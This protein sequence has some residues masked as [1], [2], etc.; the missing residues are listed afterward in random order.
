MVARLGWA[1][2]VAGAPSYVG[3]ALRQ[4]MSPLVAGATATRPLGAISGVRPGTPSSTVAATSTTWTVTAFAGV[5]DLEAAAIAGPYPFS[6]DA[7]VT[8]AVTAANASYARIDILYVRVSDPAEGDGSS[9]PLIEVLYLAGTAAAVPAAPAVPARSFVIA[10][11]NVPVSGGG[12]P[13][14]TWNAP[15][16]VAAGAP[17]PVRSQA[18]RDAKF[19]T[20]YDGLAVY[21]LDT[22]MAETYNG[23]AW[24]GWIT[25]TATTTGFTVGTTGSPVAETMWRYEGNLVRLRYR[26]K[27]GTNGAT[28][29]SGGASFTLPVSA[30]TTEQYRLGQGSISRSATEYLSLPRIDTATAVR[31]TLGTSPLVDISVSTPWGGAWAAGDTMLGE[32]TYWAA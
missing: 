31:L 2:A 21:R 23:T 4:L 14:V 1:D 17:I 29:F 10:N 30:L 8:G 26:F 18:D 9:V 25:Y 19:P 6:F 11:I 15:Y 32:I 5:I 27:F 20:P 16:A 24:S 7:N 13:T 22:H 28:A 3:R 12:S